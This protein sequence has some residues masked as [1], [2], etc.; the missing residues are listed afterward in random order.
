MELMKAGNDPELLKQMRV[1]QPKVTRIS[2]T[3]LLAKEQESIGCMGFGSWWICVKMHDFG[4][5]SLSLLGFT[6]FVF[7][8]F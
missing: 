4:Q 3:H 8:F 5:V 2:L 1:S 7:F 6:F